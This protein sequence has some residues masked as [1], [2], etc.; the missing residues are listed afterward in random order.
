MLCSGEV[1]VEARLQMRKISRLD[2]VL[3]LEAA[4]RRDGGERGI[5]RLEKLLE[6]R[7]EGLKDK[8]HFFHLNDQE[9]VQDN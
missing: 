7:L 5:I 2:S 8:E 6:T 1:S 9:N 3:L 4:Q